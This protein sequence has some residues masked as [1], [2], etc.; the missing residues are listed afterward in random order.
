VGKGRFGRAGFGRSQESFAMN[1][2]EEKKEATLES[3]PELEIVCK[4]CH[5]KWPDCHYCGGTGYKPTEFGE[6]VLALVLHHI[7]LD[8]GAIS[9]RD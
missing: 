7:G 5:G 2:N 6:K 4:H 3:L 8:S 9:R 1:E